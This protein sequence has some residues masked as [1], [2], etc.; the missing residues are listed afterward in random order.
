MPATVKTDED[1]QQRCDAMYQK[2][3]SQ[4][5]KLWYQSDLTALDVAAGIEDLNLIIEYLTK[6]NLLTLLQSG[7]GSICWKVR[8]KE[9][10]SKRS[11]LKREENM[12]YQEIEASGTTGI[13]TRTIQKKTNLHQQ[14]VT[15]CLKA[16]ENSKY[17]K[18]IKSV[19][20]PQRKIYMMYELQPAEEVT[21][22]PW[23]SDGELD[24]DFIGLISQIIVK[25][26]ERES[27]RRGP[28]VPG[29]S[30]ASKEEDQHMTMDR[31]G[32]STGR[33]APALHDGTGHILVPRDAGYQDYPTASSI[34]TFIE[35]N[36][37]LNVGRELT[38]PDLAHLLDVLVY[39]GKLEKMGI[40]ITSKSEPKA[41]IEVDDDVDLTDNGPT[42]AE[43]MYR[44]MP[45][46]FD[47]DAML[48]PGNGFSET[49]C[50]KCPVFRLCDEGGPVSASNCAYFSDWLAQ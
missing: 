26:V 7:E 32:F 44:T 1:F 41:K 9:D 10:A 15:R 37:I 24:V 34:L 36:D 30:K 23:F 8:S 13:W 25:H 21:G 18:Q 27:W 11:K 17:I 14:V 45:R 40:K 5:D 43:W 33:F 42:S 6:N 3:T 48:G 46:P 16:L 38:L 20:Y 50:S 2:C 28:L 47:E 35:S 19:K 39:D 12:I 49:P 31:L 29:W 4:T 22:G